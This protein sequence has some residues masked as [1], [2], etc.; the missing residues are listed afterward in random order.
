MAWDDIAIYNDISSH[1]QYEFAL[2]E[3]FSEEEALSFV[4]DWSRDNARTP[5]QWND[6]TNAGFTT[7]TPWLPVHEDYAVQN[8]E[9]EDKDPDSVLNYYRRLA[10]LR[11]ECPVLV[12]GDYTS[13]LD[14]S[15]TIFAY[16]RTCEN[17]EAIILVNWTEEEQVY[18]ASVEE[19]RGVLL[20]TGDH[21]AGVL[22]PHEAVILA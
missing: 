10:K 18:D 20:S 19:G 2:E 5:M 21:K 13:L 9:V 4:H 12:E 7:G 1:G 8:A 17:G 16:K 3:G 22:G 6:E 14:D 11:E 15:E